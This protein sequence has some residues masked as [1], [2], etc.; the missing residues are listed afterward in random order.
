MA[1][2]ATSRR[3]RRALLRG[4]TEPLT[5]TNTTMTNNAAHRWRHLFHVSTPVDLINDTLYDDSAP[6]G[7]EIARR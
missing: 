7:N 2:S 1:N 3:R 5:L 4:S 6:A